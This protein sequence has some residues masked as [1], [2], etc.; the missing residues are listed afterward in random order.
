[1]VV[2]F[3]FWCLFGLIAGA[4][5]QFLM[6]GDDPGHARSPMGFIITIVIGVLGA[7]LGG[8]L[9][10]RLLGWNI[11]AGFNLQSMAVAVGGSLLLLVLY[12][13]VRAAG[14]GPTRTAQ[15]H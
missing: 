10:S 4:I 3:L 5:A 15:R 9:S 6:P 2:N 7:A 8:F 12:R 11:E 1:M 13:V 14:F